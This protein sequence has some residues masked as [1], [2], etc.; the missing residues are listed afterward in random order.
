MQA[1]FIGK[2]ALPCVWPP[3]FIPAGQRGRFDWL[4]KE[5][6][7]ASSDM[8]S[9]LEKMVVDGGAVLLPEYVT[10]TRSD[11][12]TVSL[13]PALTQPHREFKRVEVVRTVRGPVA[14]EKVMEKEEDSGFEGDSDEEQEEFEEMLEKRRE[15]LT[16]EERTQED[17][18]EK[19]EEEE[20]KAE[21]E[22]KKVKDETKQDST[23]KDSNV[24]MD[25]EE[26]RRMT[27]QRRRTQGKIQIRFLN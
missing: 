2:V 3:V 20:M 1:C 22:E 10:I 25:S 24:E 13:G 19:E 23:D 6:C 8:H 7:A 21:Q 17:L 26:R 9:I 4:E 15:N 12:S 11:G 14:Q 27:K 16:D 5:I 18:D